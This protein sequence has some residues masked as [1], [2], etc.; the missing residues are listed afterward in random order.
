MIRILTLTTIFFASLVSNSRAAAIAYAAGIDNGFSLANGTN[1][2]QF[3]L[4][5]VGYF[6]FANPTV[7]I[8]ANANNLSLLNS[9]FV[10]FAN[11]KI[12][13]GFG[14]AE[15]FQ[16]LFD[17][18]NSNAEGFANKQI[19]MWVFASAG[20]SASSTAPQLFSSATQHGIFSVDPTN[21][22]NAAANQW[23]IRDNSA[24]PNNVSIDITD[25]TNAAGTALAPGAQVL[26]GSFNVGTSD[27]TSVPN[28]GLAV[29]PEPSTA[30]LAGL[31][32]LGLATRRRRC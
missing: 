28:F 20:A 30:L 4:V 8:P 31:G 9:S 7:D 29:I 17:R 1:L 15:H 19:Y 2:P 3:N 21:T 6:T 24:V 27:L 11:A 16:S 26:V 18:P 13:D 23:T 25:L 12:G 5:R 32:L 22:S 14:F 10:E